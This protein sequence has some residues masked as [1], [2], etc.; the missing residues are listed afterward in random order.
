MK[1]KKSNIILTN[2]CQNSLN[3]NPNLL[4]TNNNN[5]NKG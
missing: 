4:I 3:L 5:N 1:K 2:E